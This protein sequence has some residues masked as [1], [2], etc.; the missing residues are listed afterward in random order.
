MNAGH[1]FPK[2]AALS[3]TK[4]PIFRFLVSGG[5]ISWRIASK[6]TLTARRI[7]SPR[8][9]VPVVPIVQPLRS[10][11]VVYRTQEKPDE[12]AHDFNVHADSSL[13]S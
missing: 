9:P 2:R 7:S 11:Q 8:R 13:A 1:R 10:V 12:G 6:T 3:L 4:K 5:V